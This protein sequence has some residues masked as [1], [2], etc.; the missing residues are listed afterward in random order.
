[1]FLKKTNKICVDKGS[2]FYNRSIKSWLEKNDIQM[3]STHNEEKSVV[4][5]RFITTRK[6][7][8]YKYMTSI[9]KFNFKI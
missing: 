7:K 2:E 4:D 3:Y 6:N 1:M 8:N 9:F 5:E